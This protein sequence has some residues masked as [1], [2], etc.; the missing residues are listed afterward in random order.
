MATVL[1]TALVEETKSA[2]D[3]Y[4]ATVTNLNNDLKNTLSQLTSTNFIGDSSTGYNEFYTAKVVPAI[5]ENL[6][7]AQ[8]IT[9]NIKAILDN[10]KL[11]LLDT[12]DPQLGDANRNQ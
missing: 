4:I 12:V 3:T 6:I 9:S 2:V 7:G 1:T 5:E 8:S 11:Q 10:I